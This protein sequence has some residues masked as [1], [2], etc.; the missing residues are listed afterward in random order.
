MVIPLANGKPAGEPIVVGKDEVPADT[1][2][3]VLSAMGDV[4]ADV[5]PAS[6][7]DLMLDR[8]QADGPLP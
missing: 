3:W 6:L 8:M 4:D 5:I 7:T 1:R 2:R